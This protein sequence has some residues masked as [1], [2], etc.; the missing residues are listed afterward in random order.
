[1]TSRAALRVSVA[2]PPAVLAMA[3]LTVME[4]ALAPPRPVVRE[5]LVPLLSEAS[6]SEARMTESAPDV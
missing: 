1:M 6:M 2:S 4:P 5:T 3:L